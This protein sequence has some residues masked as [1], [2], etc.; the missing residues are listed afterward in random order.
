MRD[1]ER[2]ASFCRALKARRTAL[3]ALVPSSADAHKGLIFAEA[4]KEIYYGAG[5]VALTSNVKATFDNSKAEFPFFP[6]AATVAVSEYAC[7][8]MTS[9]LS[10]YTYPASP[11]SQ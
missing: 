7:C 4:G 1:Y 3:N 9:Y 11:Y 5:A 2:N 10:T 8:Q 6:F